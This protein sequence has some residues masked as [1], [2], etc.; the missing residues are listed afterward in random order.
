MNR[1][2]WYI[3]TAKS[4]IFIIKKKKERKEKRKTSNDRNKKMHNYSKDK[5]FSLKGRHD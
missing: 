2:K 5:L 3:H 4:Y 1:S